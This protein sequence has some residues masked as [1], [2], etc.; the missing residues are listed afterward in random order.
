MFQVLPVDSEKYLGSHRNELFLKVYHLVKKP[1]VVGLT[2]LE[3]IQEANAEKRTEKEKG[4][5]FKGDCFSISIYLPHGR[6][7]GWGI[8]IP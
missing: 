7:F 1:G 4:M 3:I 2:I 8:K 6:V 5:F